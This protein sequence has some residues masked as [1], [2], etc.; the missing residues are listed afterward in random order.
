MSSDTCL[1]AFVARLLVLAPGFSWFPGS[2]RCVAQNPMILL[3]MNS[4]QRTTFFSLPCYFRIET[5]CTTHCHFNRV[6][7]QTLPTEQ[8]A[9]V[10]TDSFSRGYDPDTHACK[11]GPLTTVGRTSLSVIIIITRHLHPIKRQKRFPQT[12]ETESLSSDSSRLR[13]YWYISRTA[14]SRLH[15]WDGHEHSSQFQSKLF[16]Q[17]PFVIR[18]ELCRDALGSDL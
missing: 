9:P 15:G 3:M 5:R 14:T 11:A 13:S 7:V 6:Q 18:G 8:D 10:S 2:F 17:F 1:S 16:Q 12:T 4:I